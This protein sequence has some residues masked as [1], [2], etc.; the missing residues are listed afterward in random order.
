M[1]FDADYRVDSSKPFDGNGI[2]RGEV[3]VVAEDYRRGVRSPG[4]GV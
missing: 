1:A 2:P 3:D 4:L